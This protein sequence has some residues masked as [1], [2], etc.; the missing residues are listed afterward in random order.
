MER[1]LGSA[2]PDGAEVMT[3]VAESFAGVFDLTPDN[4]SVEWLRETLAAHASTEPAH[5]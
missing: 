4:R 5:A 1:E 2:F 3:V